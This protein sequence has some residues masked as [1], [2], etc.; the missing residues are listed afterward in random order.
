MT[1]IDERD[2]AIQ[3]GIIAVF[4]LA[5]L[6]V[7]VYVVFGS[8]VAAYSAISLFALGFTAICLFSIRKIFL[9]LNYKEKL[10]NYATENSE[11]IDN[12]FIERKKNAEHKIKSVKSKELTKAILSGM[13][14]IFAIVVL[15]LF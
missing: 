7:V 1:Y 3:Y 12:E 4:S 8:S 11:K 10:E 5:T 14:A 2:D 6:A 9:V 15:V 13:F